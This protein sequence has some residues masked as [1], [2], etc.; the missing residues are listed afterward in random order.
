MTQNLSSKL[1]Q[2][3]I[4]IVSGGAMGVDALSHRAAGTDNTIMVAGTGIDIRYPKINSKLI[5]DIELNG[6][7][8][9]QFK[10]GSP[11][12]SRLL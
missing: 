6:L 8:L 7:V 12:N 4:C 2:N 1:S 9:S 11:S 3:G 5:E 10:T